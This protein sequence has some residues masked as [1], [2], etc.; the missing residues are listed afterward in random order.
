MLTLNPLDRIALERLTEDNGFG[1]AE[2][3]QDGWH[4]Y[5]GLAI[6][7][8]LWATRCDGGWLIGIAHGGVMQALAEDLPAAPVRRPDGGAAFR[9]DELGPV[10]RRM[11]RLARS[12]PTAPLDTFHQKTRHLPA[13]T[14]AER[15]VVQ[16]IGQDVFRTALMDYWSGTC[17]LTGI[18]EPRLLRASHIVPWAEC[19]GDAHRLD[20]HNGLLLSAL[21]DAAF[22]AG[23]VGFADDGTVLYRPSLDAAA[24]AQIRVT[25]NLRLPSLTEAHRANLTRHRAKHCFLNQS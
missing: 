7:H 12:L 19:D 23:L 8:T 20:V 15:L 2:G 16:R 24:V 17:P 9:V 22:D 3:E 18:A 4:R 13:A 21:W 11:A 25:G 6:P 5:R 1:L 10:I 14:E